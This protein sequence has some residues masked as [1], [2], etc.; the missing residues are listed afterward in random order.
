[1]RS[2]CGELKRICSFDNDG[3]RN[4]CGVRLQGDYKHLTQSLSTLEIQHQSDLIQIESV[5]SERDSLL[6]QLAARDDA[7]QAATKRQREL[8]LENGKLHNQIHT[9]VNSIES[10]ESQRTHHIQKIYEQQQTITELQSELRLFQRRLK[11]F[12]DANIE[13]QESA[14]SAENTLS[15]SEARVKA[16]ESEV[17][18][19]KQETRSLAAEVHARDEDVMVCRNRLDEAQRSVSHLKEDLKGVMQER[20][21]LQKQVSEL[22]TVLNTMS[23]SEKVSGKY[24]VHFAR[25]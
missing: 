3:D 23:G 6:Q 5:M 13:A 1:M 24:W 21:S 2:S 18:D 10:V 16:L 11:S 17:V 9:S 25:M 20:D 14:A 12:Q 8:E 7:V 15:R 19:L 4:D 22:K